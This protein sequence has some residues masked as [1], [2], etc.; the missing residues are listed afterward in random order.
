MI[1]ITNKQI[2]LNIKSYR[3]KRGFTQRYL[4]SRIGRTESSIR[5]YELG[6]V[7]IPT[8]VLEQIASE[9]NTSL[10]YLMGMAEDK[11][12]TKGLSQEVQ[13]LEAVSGA[14]GDTAMSI[15]ISFSLLNEAGQEKAC[16]YITDLAEHPKYRK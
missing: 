14:Y 13:A 6:I 1:D 7:Q 3:K 10:Y 8:D 16:E 2:G 15:L 12:E 4:A 5:K 11:P 9:L